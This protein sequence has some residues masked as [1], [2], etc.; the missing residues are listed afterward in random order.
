MKTIRLLKL[1]PRMTFHGF[2]AALTIGAFTAPVLAGT[3]VIV[4]DDEALTKC[5]EW[6]LPSPQVPSRV[7]AL[8]LCRKGPTVECMKMVYAEPKVYSRLKAA[9]VCSDN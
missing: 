6:L 4:I 2:L 7:E 1:F 8:R 9:E 3:T 5:V